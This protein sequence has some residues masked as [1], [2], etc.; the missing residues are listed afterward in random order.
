MPRLLPLYPKP[1]FGAVEV[2][3]PADLCAGRCSKCKLSKLPRMHHPA[4][5]AEG[6]S[7]GLLAIGDHPGQTEDRVGRPMMGSSGTLLRNLLKQWWTG[8]V[9]LDNAL[10]CAPGASQIV[11]SMVRACRGYLA[12]TIREAKPKRILALGPHAVYALT[13]REF[14]P[15]STRKA[16]GWLVNEGGDPIPV[17]FLMNP[18]A[19]ARNRHIRTWFEED[20]HNALTSD[21]PFPTGWGES[22]RIV[23]TEQDALDAEA[24]LR[25]A[26]W[27]AYDTETC[28]P[29]FGNFQVVTAACAPAG[30]DYAWVWDVTE[31]FAKPEVRAPLI[32]VLRD[33]AIG[34]AGQ[35]MKYD[36]NASLCEFGWNIQGAIS[37]VRLLRKLLTADADADLETMVELVGMGGHKL[38]AQAALVA[39]EGMAVKQAH[40]R[41]IGQAAVFGGAPPGV[42]REVWET[43]TEDDEPK[44]YAYGA[45]PADVRMRYCGLDAISAGRLHVQLDKW[46]AKD[47]PGITT[48]WRQIVMPAAEATKQVEAWGVLVDR[49]AFKSFQTILVA[50]LGEAR[51]RLAGYGTFDPDAPAQVSDLLFR[52]L[53]LKPQEMTKAGRPSADKQVLEGLKHEHPVVPAIIEWRHLSKLHSTYAFAFERYVRND[54]RIHPSILLDGTESGRTSCQDPNL[55]NIPSDQDEL[56]RLFRAGFIAAPGHT[57]VQIDYSQI[58]LRVAA[59]L[60]QD[61]E[62]MRIFHEGGD[63]HQ[64]TA[65]I[66]APLVWGIDPSK[67]EKRHRRGAKAFNFGILYGMGDDTIADRAGCSV[68]EAMRVRAAIMGRFKVLDRSIRDTVQKTR[69][70]GYCHTWWDGADGRRRPM[71]KIASDDPRERSKAERAAFNTRVQGTASEFLMRSLASIVEWILD[72]GVPAKLELPVHDS[73][74]IEVRNDALDEVIDTSTRIM[75]SWNSLG[76]PLEVDVEVGPTWGGLEN[77]ARKR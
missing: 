72:E 18:A 1:P 39:A 55:Q 32:R 71:H 46:R 65:E 35:N 20:L 49:S 66:I 73:V 27:F 64:R 74:L 70:T 62:M 22:A 53:G 9:A 12:Q 59:F 52:K 42:R 6:E 56:G 61:P 76:V 37:D 5:P 34:K 60:S 3:P 25:A 40:D 38:E 67:V 19:A 26:G 30:R 4:M 33:P 21:P 29:L 8:P 54:G 23:Q 17:W 58:E 63:Y 31:G 14:P 47:E 13:G 44:K 36:Q 16:F 41:A 11:P 10:R 43:M 50:R 45:L 28:G 2:C 75:Q 7:G 15:F 24:D 68:E 77:L 57:F 69:R 48:V 51:Q